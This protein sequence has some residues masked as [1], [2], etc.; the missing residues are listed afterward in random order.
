[1]FHTD[2]LWLKLVRLLLACGYCGMIWKVCIPGELLSQQLLYTFIA[3]RR[4]SQETVRHWMTC[5]LDGKV[6]PQHGIPL[7]LTKIKPS[8]IKTH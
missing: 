5:S 1:M 6:N 3:W 4:G 7:K 2:M 8:R